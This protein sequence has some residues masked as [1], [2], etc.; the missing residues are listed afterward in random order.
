L[1]IDRLYRA[2]RGKFCSGGRGLARAPQVRKH[3]LASTFSAPHRDGQEVSR[4]LQDPDLDSLRLCNP[5]QGYHW[6][7]LVRQYCMTSGSAT[8]W[9]RVWH[10]FPERKLLPFRLL[11]QHR[12]LDGNLRFKG[13]LNG[14]PVQAPVQVSTVLTIVA[15][16]GQTVSLPPALWCLKGGRTQP[17]DSSI[18]DRKMLRTPPARHHTRRFSTYLTSNGCVI[19]FLE[20]IRTVLTPPEAS[21][22]ASI[23]FHA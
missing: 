6:L 8:R 11:L 21:E 7:V 20:P 10:S 3:S 19:C 2:T 22:C 9:F 18:F 17:A 5:L 1:V 14:T 15:R 12:R 23:S 16:R 13:S 4:S